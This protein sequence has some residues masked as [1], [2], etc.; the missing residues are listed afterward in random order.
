MAVLFIHIRMA[1]RCLIPV[2]ALVTATI[3][4]T[5]LTDIDPMLGITAISHTEIMVGA[6][7]M[8]EALVGLDIG[9]GE[10]DMT[11]MVV[12]LT[13]AKIIDGGVDMIGTAV[14]LTEAEI[15]AGVEDMVGAAE[16]LTVAKIIDGG[17]DMIGTAVVLTVAKIIAG[18][19]AIVGVAMVGTEGVLAV[20]GIKEA[21]ADRAV[22]KVDIICEQFKFLQYGVLVKNNAY[23]IK[24]KRTAT[25]SMLT[26]LSQSSISFSSG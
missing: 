23:R 8:A 26:K 21:E 24:V 18:G 16:V 20:A 9:G 25:P 4:A 19:T 22:T 11:G 14:V 17:V 2:I 12:V 1:T 6:A 13:V 3:M 15:I 10:G 5:R 7:V